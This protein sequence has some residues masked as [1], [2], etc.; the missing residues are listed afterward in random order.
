MK[1][2]L[3]CLVLL[4]SVTFGFSQTA[5]ETASILMEK[6]ILKKSRDIGDPEVSI[7]S[8]Y[9]L[10]ALEGEQSKYKDTLAY[11]YFSTRKYA[12]CYMITTEVLQRDP[13]NLEMLEIRAISLESL[14]AF[15]KAAEDYSNLFDIT[16]N[17]FHGYNLAKLQFSLKKNE[18][19]L[20][21]IEK[22]EKLNDAGKYTVSYAVNKRHTQEV[23]LLAAISYLKGLIT[24]ELGKKEEAKASF[25]KA[26]TIQSDFTL[27]KEALESL[28]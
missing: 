23:E 15:D 16:K 26:I 11:M 6:Q 7:S 10:I 28:K 17:N 18:E 8:I 14:G 20:V 5:N 27:A 9:R 25:E 12:P 1:L 22:T 21:T 24:I 4:L 2:N 19:A 13:K 3:L